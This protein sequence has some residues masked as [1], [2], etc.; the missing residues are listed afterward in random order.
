MKTSKVKL[1]YMPNVN[2]QIVGISTSEIDYKLAFGLVRGFGMDFKG[3]A[4]DHV[5]VR[6]C[7]TIRAKYLFGLR[8]RHRQFPKVRPAANIQQAQRHLPY[9]RISQLRLPFH[10]PRLQFVRT[11]QGYDC[12]ALNGL[13]YRSIPFAI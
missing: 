2:F 4:A 10:C 3:T 9:R 12:F 6:Q 13:Y 1:D 8:K 5:A 11:R 7:C